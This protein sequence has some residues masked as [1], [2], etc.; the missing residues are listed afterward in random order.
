MIRHVPLRVTNEMVRI[1]KNAIVVSC[2]LD[3]WVY[4]DEWRWWHYY[5][6]CTR[7]SFSFVF[8]SISVY[9]TFEIN[10]NDA[11]YTRYRA[12]AP[13]ESRVVFVDSPRAPTHDIFL[14]RA[15][16]RPG[17]IDQN[18]FFTL[19]VAFPPYTPIVT[20]VTIWRRGKNKSVCAPSLFDDV[21]VFVPL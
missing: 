8:Y 5:Y 17:G 21:V 9:T 12:R 10:E 4:S 16:L 15:P 1:E 14:L 6:Y 2:L 19:L 7:V 11:A 18:W 3:L 13:L 20:D